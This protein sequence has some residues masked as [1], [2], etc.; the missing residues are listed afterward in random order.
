[1]APL[2][3]DSLISITR[4]ARYANSASN[5]LLKTLPQ[6]NLQT[7]IILHPVTIL[8]LKKIIKYIFFLRITGEQVELNIIAA[9]RYKR[10]LATLVIH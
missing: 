9:V 3:K 10:K 6:R 5:T 7:Y 8:K 4:N 1:M 2:V